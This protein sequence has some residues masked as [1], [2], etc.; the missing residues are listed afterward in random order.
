MLANRT[1]IFATFCRKPGLKRSLCRDDPG[2]NVVFRDIT[3]MQPGVG[4]L[5]TFSLVPVLIIRTL[6]NADLLNVILVK[7]AS[8][9][10]DASF[11]SLFH[12]S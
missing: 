8:S 1:I 4:I 9:S 5:N 11:T 6:L 2:H 10:Y 12:F 7:Y 3:K